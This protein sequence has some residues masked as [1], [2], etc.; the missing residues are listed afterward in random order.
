MNNSYRIM[1][2]FQKIASN[3][4]SMINH[5]SAR[6]D[7]DA[8]WQRVHSYVADIAKDISVCYSKLARL[9]G[10]FEGEELST[11]ER[12]SESILA[13][14]NEMSS[15]LKAFYEGKYDMVDKSFSYG[16]KSDGEQMEKSSDADHDIDFEVKSEKPEKPEKPE[17]LEEIKSEETYEAPTKD[18]EDYESKEES[19]Q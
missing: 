6:V 9:E 19:E 5:Y 13:L 10:D 17:K 16:Q 11:L 12:I 18:D 7:K 14:G 8:E 2:N 3:V 1:S 15:F 4:F